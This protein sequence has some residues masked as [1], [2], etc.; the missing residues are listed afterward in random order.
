MSD[1]VKLYQRVAHQIEQGIRTGQY[2][3]GTRLPPERDLADTFQVS[4]PTIRE[5]MIALE[6]RNFVEVRHGS[7]I[8]VSNSRPVDRAPAELDVGAFELIE[9]RLMFEGEAAA[10][11]AK[12]MTD[13]ELAQV[14]KILL[15]MEALDATFDEEMKLDRDFHMAIAEGTRSSLVAQT[16]EHLWDLREQSPLC[17]HM[18][19]QARSSGIIP[20]PHEHRR[21][22]EALMARDADR[23]RAAMRAHLARVSE[24]LLAMTELELIEKAKR[25]IDEKRRR[26]VDERPC[27]DPIA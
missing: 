17:R 2:L 22:Y 1:R 5:A 6:I 18:F 12:V 9:A 13:E 24:D 23:A 3:V 14:G 16:I 27:P 15:R 7:G 4:R 21:I 26:I 25:E 11:A 19:D 10:L 20:R 8:Y